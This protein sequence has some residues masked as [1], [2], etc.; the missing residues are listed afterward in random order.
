MITT[1]IQVLSE[2]LMNQSSDIA[3]FIAEDK[4]GTP[5]GFVHLQTGS[6]YYNHDKH[7]HVANIIVAA[8]G[9]DRPLPLQHLIVRFRFFLRLGERGHF[10]DRVQSKVLQ[11]FRAGGI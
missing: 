10:K 7:G 9:E 2:K 6:D 8:E 3:I 5:L 11:E 4:K 1:D